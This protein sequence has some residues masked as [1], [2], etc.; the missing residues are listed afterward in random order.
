M[1]TPTSTFAD[2][3]NKKLGLV[4]DHV[5]DLYEQLDTVRGVQSQLSDASKSLGNQI[6]ALNSKI[7]EQITNGTLNIATGSRYFS[8]QESFDLLPITAI[9]SQDNVRRFYKLIRD[10]VLKA[11]PW[12]D[13]IR[14]HSQPDERWDMTLVSRR[15]YGNPMEFMTVLAA[16][17]LDSVEQILPEQL[18]TLPTATV[19][20]S[21]K[22]MAG[23]ENNPDYRT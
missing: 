5:G 13:A 2:N 21:L 20:Y 8:A 1:T 10:F 4:A 15:V 22:K 19:L 6:D 17:N 16:A 11:K 7:S 18:L 3:E 14:Y 12:T 23:F 9:E